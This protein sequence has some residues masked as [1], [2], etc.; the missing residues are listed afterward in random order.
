[1]EPLKASKS[2]GSL[3]DELSE[4]ER[5]FHQQ[6]PNRETPIEVYS[7]VAETHDDYIIVSM[8]DGYYRVN[9][10]GSGDDIEF[11]ER[12]EWQEVER[13]TTWEA[14]RLRRL[15]T[16]KF[17]KADEDEL[18]LDGYLALWGGVDSDGEHFTTET[19]FESSYT[20][21]GHLNV[22]WEHGLEPDEEEDGTKIL[23]P[24]RDDVLGYVEWMTARKDDIGL[25][26]RHVL[27]RRERYVSEFVEPL[28]RAGLIG[29]ST[30]AIQTKVK[31][32][33]DGTITVWPL[34]RQ[35]ITV[36]PAESR[37]MTDQQL[38]IIKSLAEQYPHLKAYVPKAAGT[39]AT[40]DAT[41]EGKQK[42]QSNSK[43]ESKMTEINE[44]LVAKI[45]ADAAAAAVKAEREA[46]A[47]E[48]KTRAELE[49]HDKEV[50]EAAIKAYQEANPP[51]D[52]FGT[53]VNV[54]KNSEAWQFDNYSADDL[55]AVLEIVGSATGRKSGL[56]EKS[57]AQ[58][59]ALVKTLALRLESD[60][61]KDESKVNI[62]G[63][64][65]IDVPGPLKMASRAMKAA[66]V[67]ANELN[68]ST[69]AGFGDEWIGVAYGGQLW[70]AVRESAP[71]VQMVPQFEF[72]PGAE[73][74][75]IPVESTD[76]IWYLVAEAADPGATT[77]LTYTVPAKAV[78]TASKT[79]TLS[80]LGSSTLY[81]G[82]MVEGSVLPFVSQL[83]AQITLSA[84][85]YLTHS[86]IDGDTETGASANVNDIA[87]TPVGNE[88]FLAFNGFRKSPLVTT[89]GNSRDGGVI[90]SSDFLETVKLMGVG[91]KVGYDR[92]RVSF[93]IDPNVNWKVLELADVKTKDV[94]TNA[95]LES[96]EL[97]QIYGYPVI[98]SYQMHFASVGVNTGYEYKTE[99]SGKID[100]NTASDN[101]KGAILA[102]RW[103][104][105]RL[106]FR[107]RIT[108][109]VARIQRADS[110][111]I[112]SMMRA[113]LA[114]RDTEASSISYNLTV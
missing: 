36:M 40:N 102:V 43:G 101:T 41:A 54:A 87:S 61:A 8:D 83:R 94:F 2:N 62:G 97:V 113:G 72:P 53:N 28:S 24:N 71:V 100:L 33:E 69:N 74:L 31:K 7:W 58:R 81:T 12:G 99:S 60:E 80:K 75:V 93:I 46:R 59:P 106:G 29:S 45:A 66:G 4:I 91:G 108:T 84:G 25:L 73:S 17:I 50:V 107:R 10:S 55:A 57:E 52:K 18:H 95:T 96:G 110:W 67:K 5:A 15:K 37:L 34:K 13:N 47:A 88:A 76:P 86:I 14:K 22:D 89:T 79:M 65:E 104:H 105:W 103:D 38:S 114:Q 82:E 98:V 48:E 44:E 6:Y 85:E 56:V 21:T 63:G 32:K 1:M 27:D 90:S 26:A 20:R 77:R 70:E 78:A 3:E 39:A 64:R 112:T 9:Y 19:D 23:Q 35:S 49:A 51:E 92:R 68:Y 11:A 16:L 109:E 111:D 30:E 42:P